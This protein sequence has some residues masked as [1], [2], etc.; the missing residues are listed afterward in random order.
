MATQD[1]LDLKDGDVIKMD[2]IQHNS[3]SYS[4]LKLKR[5]YKVIN[6]RCEFG[7]SKT[8]I[9]LYTYDGSGYLKRR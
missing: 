3:W 1:M 2:W 8:L 7:A 4:D 9:R 6:S 5:Y